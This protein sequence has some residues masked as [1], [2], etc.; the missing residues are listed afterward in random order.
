MGKRRDGNG[1]VGL[2]ATRLAQEQ[3]RPS[4]V[5]EPQPGEVINEGRVDGGLELEVELSKGLSEREPGETAPGG[6]APVAAGRHLLGQGPRERH[7]KPA[8]T[9]INPGVL[10]GWGEPSPQLVFH[11]ANARPGWA[12]VVPVRISPTAGLSGHDGQVVVSPWT[13]GPLRPV[14]RLSNIQSVLVGDARAR[15]RSLP[16]GR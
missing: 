5:H 1:E 8:H 9:G 11:S 4:G 15:G 12:S 13:Q 2:A 14:K 7:L 16:I 6:E 3:D 10:P